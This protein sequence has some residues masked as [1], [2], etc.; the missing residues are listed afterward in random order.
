MHEGHLS[1]IARARATCDVVVVSI[2]VNP[3]QFSANEDFG[4]YP[5]AVEADLAKISTAGGDAVF[6][7]KSLYA[8]DEAGDDSKRVI[9]APRGDAA[10]TRGGGSASSSSA[11]HSTWVTVEGPSSGLCGASRPHFFRGVATVVTKLFNIVDPDRAFFGK[12]DYQ[13]WRVLQRL[14]RDL[15]FGIEVVGVDTARAEDGLALSSR[16]ALLTPEDRARAP[17]I[18]RA[19]L[20]AK[21]AAEAAIA[22]GGEAADTADALSADAIC[23][24]V[25]EAI[26]KAGGKID[27]VRVV[28]AHTMEPIERIEAGRLALLATAAA[29]GAVRLIDNIEIGEQQS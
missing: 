5:R 16:N 22:A 13:Q 25:S 14:A 18:R 20:A 3:T 8:G 19:L 21:T 24:A 29:F 4:D 23:G 26:S 10:A 17:A 28:N 12:K 2:Y 6:T 7:P 15:S 27:Y 1:L 11:A 9:G